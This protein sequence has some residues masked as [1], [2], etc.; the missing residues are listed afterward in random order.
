MRDTKGQLQLIV[1]IIG[2]TTTSRTAVFVLF[3]CAVLI[4][5]LTGYLPQQAPQSL[6]S[7]RWPGHYLAYSKTIFSICPIVSQPLNWMLNVSDTGT[8]LASLST[9]SI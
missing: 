3:K 5:W 4:P 9:R 7:S 2:T 8:G 1:T 6:L